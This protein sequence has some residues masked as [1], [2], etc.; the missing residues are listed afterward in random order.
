MRSKN[1]KSP[2]YPA[3]GVGSVGFYSLQLLPVHC[4]DGDHGYL[5]YLEFANSRVRRRL[6]TSKT[7]QP[8]ESSHLFSSYFPPSHFSLIPMPVVAWL[9]RIMAAIVVFMYG[10]GRNTLSPYVG[11][12]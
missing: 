11:D 10:I 1:H 12:T 9:A 2:E 5:W 6:Q 4:K 8:G 3:H 7:G